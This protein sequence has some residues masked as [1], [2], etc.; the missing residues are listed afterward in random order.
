[1]PRGIYIHKQLTEQTK[2]KL[3]KSHKGKRLTEEH[4]RKIR[5]AKKGIIPKMAGW[6]KGKETPIEVKLKISKSGKGKI[7]SE[8]SKRRYSESKKGI[9][10]PAWNGGIS[11]LTNSIRRCFEY[12]QWR[13]DIFTRDNFTC[14]LCGDN[15]GGNL[16]ADHIKNMALILRENKVATIKQAILCEELWNLNNGRTLCVP[17]HKKTDNFGGRANKYL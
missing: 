4:K 12:R 5:E 15:K 14:V 13:S 16:N 10:N 3:S 8:E 17:C 2:I 6:N 9:K 11:P 1:M 7:R